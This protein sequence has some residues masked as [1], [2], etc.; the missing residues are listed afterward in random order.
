MTV[1]KISLSKANESPNFIGSWTIDPKLCDDLVNFFEINHQKQMRGATSSGIK[2][3]AKNRQD[4]SIYPKSIED[5]GNELFKIYFNLLFDCYRDYCQQWP[6]LKKMANRL[7]IGAFNLGRYYPGQHFK[8]LHTERASINTLQ[9]LFA[10]MTYLNNVEEG[11]STYFKYYDLDIRPQK[12]LTII[13][14]A[15]WTHLHQG[16]VVEAGSKYIITGWL[17]FPVD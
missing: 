12:G 16:K 13:W 7:E 9:R 15:E 5:P 1:Q 8:E 2:P 3:D 6:F 17:N 10:F 14:P 11:G 4:I